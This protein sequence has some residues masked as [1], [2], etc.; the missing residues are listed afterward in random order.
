MAV[1]NHVERGTK[2]GQPADAVIIFLHG[3]GSNGQRTI[4]NADGLVDKF[5]NAHFYAPDAHN[6]YVPAMDPSLP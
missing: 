2:S 1:Y 3:M 6:P 5:P 4:N